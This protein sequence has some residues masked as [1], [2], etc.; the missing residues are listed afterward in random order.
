MANKGRQLTRLSSKRLKEISGLADEVVSEFGSDG[1]IDISAILKS[2]GISVSYGL[3]D[4]AFDGM[5]EHE[6][7]EFHIYCN[8]NRV[9]LNT[10]T[11][12]RFTLGH[13]LGHYYIDQHRNEL[14]AGRTI[15][16]G[17]KCEYESFNPA[18]QE[19]DYFASNLLMPE[20][21][22]KKVANR[23]S[24]GLQGIIELSKY[25]NTSVTSTA[26]RYVYLGIK[27][28]VVIKWDSKGYQWRWL[29]D[30][31]RLGFYWKTID[32]LDQIP[33]DSPTG[34][35]FAEDALP[36]SGYFE[37]GSTASAWFSCVKPGSY[38]DIILIE[39]A[40]PL[41]KYGVLTFIYPADGEFPHI[42]GRF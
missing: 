7:G 32:S 41:G 5:L 12:A 37:S 8:L 35:A 16:H 29:S 10:S 14:I 23:Y 1:R 25:F 38:K 39:Q 28:S 34:R 11:R 33:I 27:P 4:D 20:N 13:E 40:V 21:Y 42:E 26:I 24:A 19:A 2:N 18:E 30:E 3:Y 9:G 6:S 31:A 15:S 36:E 22:F 17:S